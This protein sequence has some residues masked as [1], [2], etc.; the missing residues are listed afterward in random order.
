VKLYDTIDNNDRQAIAGDIEKMTDRPLIS[1]VMPVFNTPEPYL[2]AAIASV[3][4][5]LYPNWELCIA[6]DASTASHIRSILEHY[7]TIDSRIKVYYRSEN[8]HISA[9]SNSALALAKGSFYCS[10]RSTYCRNTRC[11]WSPRP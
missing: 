3:R 5:Q 11:I 7:R 10:P 4:Q 2:R 8:G 6:D 9:A 1:V